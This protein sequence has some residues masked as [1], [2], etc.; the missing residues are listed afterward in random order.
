MKKIRNIL[1][2]AHCAYCIVVNSM[3]RFLWS[4]F[5]THAFSNTSGE[6]GHKFTYILLTF[7]CLGILYIAINY[8][9]M[10]IEMLF[11]HLFSF[12]NKEL[13]LKLFFIILIS[14]SLLIIINS[15]LAYF[16]KTT[17]NIMYINILCVFIFAN[18]FHLTF[19]PI[20]E[21]LI[22][23]FI[24]YKSHKHKIIYRS[25]FI[26]FQIITFCILYN[27]LF[28]IL[29]V[30]DN[31]NVTENYYMYFHFVC[32]ICCIFTG[33]YC[34]V[35]SVLVFVL[36][37]SI[38]DKKNIYYALLWSSC[39]LLFDIFLSLG[40]LHYQKL[41]SHNF[42]TEFYN[43]INVYNFEKNDEIREKEIISIVE[44]FYREYPLESSYKIYDESNELIDMKLY[45]IC[46]S[47]QYN[48]LITYINGNELNNLFG[49]NKN[50]K[51]LFIEE[52]S[53]FCPF[54]YYLCDIFAFPKYVFSVEVFKVKNYVLMINHEN[55]LSQITK[56]QDS[57]NLLYSII[58][59]LKQYNSELAFWELIS[60]YKQ[61]SDCVKWVNSNIKTY[62]ESLIFDEQ[63]LVNECY[64]FKE[65]YKRLILYR[66]DMVFNHNF[67]K[68]K[69]LL[70]LNPF[71]ALS[72]LKE[73]NSLL[74][75]IINTPL[76][77]FAFSMNNSFV[78]DKLQ[79]SVL[80][81]D[82]KYL[83]NQ[84]TAISTSIHLDLK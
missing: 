44:V 34:M 53:G 47:I 54:D 64:G 69:Q 52:K 84:I 62:C 35:Y 20:L 15:Y 67:L 61:Y 2:I 39:F 17:L 50:Q 36:N 10:K 77:H 49:N 78:G 59:H 6:H 40:I 24:F 14:T 12:E 51:E 55:Y 57:I 79:F 11:F 74:F 29:I 27:S 48:K 18:S 41:K 68:Y 65:K 22:L 82:S 72:I 83:I 8:Y 58:N 13:Y 42:Y 71:I 26:N 4:F 7:G 45:N 56:I 23:L 66:I 70:I 81:N 43:S 60:Y 19:F 21:M 1:D 38:N 33:I 37:K 32:Q 25:F 76:D 75:E 3:Q 63:L 28:Y 9:T 30:T 80:Q 16:I 46:T 31:L 73:Y 5:S